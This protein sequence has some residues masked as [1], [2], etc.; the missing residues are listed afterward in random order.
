MDSLWPTALPIAGV[1]YMFPEWRGREKGEPIKTW[2]RA[3]VARLF[4]TWKNW[5][6]GESR[7]PT[8]R[9]QGQERAPAEPRV[10]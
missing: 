6:E 4:K 3:D 7:L 9:H 10:M 1:Q 5:P 8:S 2:R